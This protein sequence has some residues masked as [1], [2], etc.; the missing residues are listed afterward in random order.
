LLIG[1]PND[2][3]TLYEFPYV[4]FNELAKS[5]GLAK[6]STYKYFDF[7]NNVKS[8]REFLNIGIQMLFLHFITTFRHKV[9]HFLTTFLPL[10]LKSKLLDLY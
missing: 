10:E 4:I 3:I 9:I 2:K 6:M 8:Q 7:I 1:Y 5:V